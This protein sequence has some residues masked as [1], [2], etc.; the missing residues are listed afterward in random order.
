V[1]V[2]I[3]SRSAPVRAADLWGVEIMRTANATLLAFLLLSA[4]AEGA[5][6]GSVIDMHLHADRMEDVPPGTR[7]CPGDQRVLIP[8]IDPKGARFLQ[9]R[10]LRGADTCGRRR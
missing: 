7:A 3:Q 5:A 2:I 9:V 10:H 8:T 6:W 4:R 1:Y